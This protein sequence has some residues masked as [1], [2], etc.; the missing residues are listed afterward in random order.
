MVFMGTDT[1]KL[2]PELWKLEPEL[3]WANSFASE[4]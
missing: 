2:E 1:S 3:V 4:T